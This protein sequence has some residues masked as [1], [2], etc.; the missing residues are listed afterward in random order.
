M[1][2]GIFQD[3]GA[4]INSHEEEEEAFKFTRS[5]SYKLKSRSFQ[6]SRIKGKISGTFLVCFHR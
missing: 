1:F 5:Q 3:D 6:R 2:R 4:S